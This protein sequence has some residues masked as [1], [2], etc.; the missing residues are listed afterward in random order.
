M[1]AVQGK[2]EASLKGAKR[3]G[4]KRA[5]MPKDIAKTEA[6]KFG[7]RLSELADKANLTA[8]ELGA[9]IG[10]SGDTVRLYFS[11]KAVPHLNDWP[12]VAKALG[13]SLSALYPH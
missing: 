7:V 12:L 1:V 13:V 4:K 11:G 2:M 10:K 3:V 9:K 8:D 6:G 5:A